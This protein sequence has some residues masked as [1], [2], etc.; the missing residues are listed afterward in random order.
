M[1]IEALISSKL[2]DSISKEELPSHE[3]ALIEFFT[4]WNG[5]SHIMN[6]IIKEVQNSYRG[7]IKLFRVDVETDKKLAKCFGVAKA[8]MFQIYHKGELI[9]QL[10]GIVSKKVLLNKLKI[11]VRNY[12]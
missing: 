1:N 8:P 6:P 12:S 11:I 9:E 4:P 10:E 5:A 7:K 2:P 3:F